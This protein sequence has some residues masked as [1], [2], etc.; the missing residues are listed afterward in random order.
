MRFPAPNWTLARDAS[1]IASLVFDRVGA[2]TNTLSQQMLVELNDAL[3]ALERD[4]P[5]GLIVRSGKP[6][7]FIAGADV[8]EFGQL[9]EPSA[10]IA[11]VKR[12]WDTFERLAAVPYP[13]L[14]L[15]K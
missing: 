5:K 8:T 3:D 2:S 4:P 11:L 1:G 7:G 12:G 10:A 14:A 15:I 9:T 6:N 13:T